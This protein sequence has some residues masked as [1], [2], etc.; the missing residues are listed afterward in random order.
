MAIPKKPVKASPEAVDAFITGS[1]TDQTPPQPETP[2]VQPQSSGAA[3]ALVQRPRKKPVRQ[4]EIVTRQTFVINENIVI[5]LEAY[6]FWNRMTKK[7][8]LELAL[9]QFYADKKIRPIPRQTDTEL[10]M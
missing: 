9:T 7:S 4:K 3:V 6:A 8:V 10:E 5:K 1:K 2:P